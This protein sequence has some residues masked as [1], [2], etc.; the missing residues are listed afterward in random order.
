MI[1]E[2]KF[3]YT[4]VTTN[5]LNGKQYVGD[6]STNNLD[7]GYLG[8]GVAIKRSIQKYGEE[9]FKKEILEFFDTKQ[10]AFDAQEKWINEHNS[11]SPNGYNISP[12]GGVGVTG[13][14]SEETKQKIS[15]SISGEKNPFYGKTHTEETKQKLSV[16]ASLRTGKKNVMFG[17][18]LYNVWLEKYGE[19]EANIRLEQMKNKMSKTRKGRTL[20]PEH[21]K[22]LSKA[23]IGLIYE[24]IECPHCRK[25]ADPGNYNRWHGSNCKLNKEYINK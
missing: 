19:E 24:K 11:M 3:N 5:I 7:D 16:A 22:N 25:K 4:Y 9:N 20:T 23:K 17:E 12:L 18:D 10:Q 1:M 2:K 13:C 14:F 21:C 15:E 6:H 8:S